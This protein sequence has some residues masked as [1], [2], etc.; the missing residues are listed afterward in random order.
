[1]GV[2]RLAGRLGAPRMRFAR[3]IVANQ[4]WIACERPGLRFAIGLDVSPHVRVPDIR[5]APIPALE[6]LAIDEL[7][8]DVVLVPVLFEKPWR[9]V[10]VLVVIDPRPVMVTGM[11]KLHPRVAG[12]GL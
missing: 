11:V 10:G 6:H 7:H 1:T 4:K 2:L 12:I 9:K 8:P 5:L 3:V